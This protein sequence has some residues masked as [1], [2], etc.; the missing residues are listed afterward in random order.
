MYFS[1]TF[2]RIMVDIALTG[3]AAAAIVLVVLLIKDIKAKQIW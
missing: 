2:L 1:A 3:I